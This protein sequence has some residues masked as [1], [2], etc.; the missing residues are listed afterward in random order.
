MAIYNWMCTSQC[1]TRVTSPPWWQ[2]DGITIYITG[3]NIN[4]CH[5]RNQLVKQFLTVVV[6]TAPNQFAVTL[7][8]AAPIDQIA[9][10]IPQAAYQHHGMERL[11]HPS[12][13]NLNVFL[14]IAHL[15]HEIGTTNQ[16]HRT[17]FIYIS[18]MFSF[19]KRTIWL[20]LLFKKVF[21]KAAIIYLKM[22]RLGWLLL[23]RL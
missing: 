9:M 10:I 3:W 21:I 4:T 6:F 12:I 13:D 14:F 18:S 16:T 5:I 22:Y 19:T 2:S 23:R 20:T 7:T 17:L 15:V 11:A 8:T 1:H